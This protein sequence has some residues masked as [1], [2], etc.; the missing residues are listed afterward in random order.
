MLIQRRRGPMAALACTAAL[1]AG[2]TGCSRVS[3][4]P[5]VDRPTITYQGGAMAETNDADVVVDGQQHKVD[6]KIACIAFA[7]GETMISIGT[8]PVAVKITLAN[9]RDAPRVRMVILQ[10]L[11]GYT[12]FVMDPPEKGEASVSRDGNRYIIGGMSWG[13]DSHNDD[14]KK[15]F[16]IQ[17]TCP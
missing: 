1:T 8:E 15:P 12:L 11:I 6:G 7:G 9:N 2:L 5:S 17:F 10:N 3:F 16:R 13:L 14:V 4:F